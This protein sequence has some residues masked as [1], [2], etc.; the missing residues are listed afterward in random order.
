MVRTSLTAGQR[1]AARRISVNGDGIVGVQGNA[2]TGKT[3]MLKEVAG[4]RARPHA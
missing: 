4:R 3:T 2:G 1:E